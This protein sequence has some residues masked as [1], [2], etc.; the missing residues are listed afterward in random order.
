G[1]E[2]RMI[3]IDRLEESLRCDL[4]DAL[5]IAVRGG[6]DRL[7]S[8][9][10]ENAGAAAL[11]RPPV[12]G[13][14]RDAARGEDLPDVIAAPDGRRQRLADAEA[15]EH[16]VVARDAL[17]E[18]ASAGEPDAVDG[19]HAVN[20]RRNTR[21]ERC[22]AL[23]GR[24]AGHTRGGGG[25]GESRLETRLKDL[26]GQTVDGHECSAALGWRGQDLDRRRRG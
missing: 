17:N 4:V 2:L 19:A 21:A 25:A 9:R 5:R 22:P 11:G 6:E 23:G 3:A 8:D 7:L 12:H 10:V 20:R 1:R 26:V 14:A 18:M 13:E 24:L 15:A 16:E